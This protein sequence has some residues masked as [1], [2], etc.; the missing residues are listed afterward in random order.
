MTPILTTFNK[1]KNFNG[2][3]NSEKAKKTEAIVSWK[4][5]ANNLPLA[6]VE[7]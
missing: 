5:R 4:P 6:L 1:L 7:F 3:I 2:A